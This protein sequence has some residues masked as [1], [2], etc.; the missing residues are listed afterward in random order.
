MSACGLSSLQGQRPQAGP[1]ALPGED[2]TRNR[3]APE[4]SSEELS[5]KEP[6]MKL[7]ISCLLMCACFLSSLERVLG[8]AGPGAWLAR[9]GHWYLGSP[10]LQSL[11]RWLVELGRRHQTRGGFLGD[12]AAEV[13]GR[14]SA[15]RCLG[16]LCGGQL[17]LARGLW[18]RAAVAAFLRAP[19]SRLRLESSLTRVKLTFRLLLVTCL[20]SDIFPQLFNREEVRQEKIRQDRKRSRITQRICKENKGAILGSM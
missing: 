6:R 16:V 7:V 2:C 11:T 19:G 14:S 4:S 15:G 13:I 3:A 18:Q 8:L 5:S 9:T 17:S 1:A 10:G 20:E 12:S